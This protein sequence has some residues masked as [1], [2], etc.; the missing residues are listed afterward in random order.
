[1]YAHIL[2]A[3]MYLLFRHVIRTWLSVSVP[4]QYNTDLP[5]HTGPAVLVHKNILFDQDL[6]LRH[7]MIRMADDIV[8]VL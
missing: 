8:E 1:M 2:F 3:T 7:N 6:Q 5:E 4:G